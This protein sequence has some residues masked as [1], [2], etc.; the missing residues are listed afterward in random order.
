MRK[1]LALLAL[2]LQSTLVH[3]ALAEAGTDCPLAHQPYSSDTV[4]FD[5]LLNPATKA[6]L[7]KDAGPLMKAL[8]PFFL[9][10]TPPTFA[11]IISLRML[12]SAP[13]PLGPDGAGPPPVDFDALDADLKAVP[14]THEASVARCARY[15]EAAVQLPSRIKQPALLVFTKINGFRDGPSVDAGT[16][17]LKAMAARR[18][19]T[20]VFTDRAAAFNAKQLK[21]FKAVIWNNISGDAL[22]LT[23][24][25]A[26]QSYLEHGGGFAAFHGSGGDPLYV[27][28]WYA[29]TLI[30]A[31]F[32]GHPMT[33]QFQDA[34]VVV[35][36]PSDPI[37]AGLGDGW[38]MTEEW[39]SFKSS[40]RPKG[41]HVL[42]RLDESTYKPFEGKQDLRMGDHPI[43]WTR[44]LGNGR[45]FYTAIGH[46][47]ENYQEPHSVT[48]LENGIAWAAGLGGTQCHDDKEVPT[49]P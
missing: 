15:D 14:V 29:D 49:K 26:L 38:N 5:L 10:T 39:Y 40:P 33:P 2:G 19:W 1:T 12:A 6:V 24:Q 3:S 37:V 35:D 28:D 7:D 36:D 22:T 30:G 8:P 43:A 18:G 27:W 47:P 13:I 9:G 48:L 31:R 45:S 11:T 21:H 32:I 25:R 20:L 34:R 42:A 41:V 46:R 44:C 4:L 16:A 23:Q 17:A